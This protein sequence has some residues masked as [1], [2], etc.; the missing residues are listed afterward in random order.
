MMSG[1]KARF[2]I[3]FWNLKDDELQRLIWC[4]MLEPGLAHKM[5]NRR[6]QGFGSIRLTPVAPCYLID[7]SKR[8]IADSE[9]D[10]QKD[11]KVPNKPNVIKHHS[12]LNSHLNDANIRQEQP[13]DIKE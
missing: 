8:Y 2:S 13:K 6:Y 4:V 11:L 1:S 12:Q 7:W 3:R 5:G 9:V 10:W